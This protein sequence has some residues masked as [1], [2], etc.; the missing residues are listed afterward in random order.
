MDARERRLAARDAARQAVNWSLPATVATAE[1]AKKLA[2]DFGYAHPE[3]GT[4]KAIHAVL[5]QLDSPM[6]LTSPAAW[7]KHGVGRGAFKR[8]KKLLVLDF[9]GTAEVDS[10]DSSLASALESRDARLARPQIPHVWRSAAPPGSGASPACTAIGAHGQAPAGGAL[11]TMDDAPIAGELHALSVIAG[12]AE[13]PNVNVLM[14]ALKAAALPPHFATRAPSEPAV[15]GDVVADAADTAGV[16]VAEA[17]D[18]LILSAADRHA[19]AIVAVDKAEAEAV[20]REREA[21]DAAHGAA[22]AAQ[23]AAEAARAAEA[24]KERAREAAAEADSA[25]A[26][27]AAARLAAEA[28]AVEAA[29]EAAAREEARE[30]EQRQRA[31]AAATAAGS[32]SGDAPP[33]RPAKA[34][35]P[36]GAS[37]SAARAQALAAGQRV[38]INGVQKRSELNGTYGRVLAFHADR[39]RYAV[40]LEG[41]REHVQTCR[42]GWLW[43]AR[44]GSPKGTD[45]QSLS[46]S[47]L[48]S[49]N[50]DMQVAR[51]RLAAADE[52]AGGGGGEVL[53][54]LG[55]RGGRPA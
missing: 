5:D 46:H 2:Y 19:A 4:C 33:P 8:W 14:Q 12:V 32:S 11:A 42:D 44:F 13:R 55:R 35:A 27:V 9:L 16:S 49:G 53:G 48:I 3:A 25:R 6:P 37:S 52:A 10:T 38:C 1:V 22:D 28:A 7:E 54:M 40:E 36:D 21:A 43:H 18:K 47:P 51:A 26:R 20:L 50:P 15:H 29:G 24:A 34:D 23:N 45:P 39:G 30:A 41:S 17:L 31:E